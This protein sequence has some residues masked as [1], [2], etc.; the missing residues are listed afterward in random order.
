MSMCALETKSFSSLAVHPSGEP[1][2]GAD[3]AL[4]H[5][6]TSLFVTRTFLLSIMRAFWGEFWF[7]RLPDASW[8]LKFTFKRRSPKELCVRVIAA[9][10]QV[11]YVIS[12]FWTETSKHITWLQCVS[13][14]FSRQFFVYFPT[15]TA[16]A[17]SEAH[18]LASADSFILV[19]SPISA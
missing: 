17:S 13:F 4:L 6:T 15:F 8:T 10:L 11:Q 12:I 5:V 9:A 16:G 2:T 7:L 3:S 14:E 19:K 1:S 18:R